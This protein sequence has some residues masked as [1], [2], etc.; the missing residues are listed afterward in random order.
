MAKSAI[1]ERSP[2]LVVS[3]TSITE[4][5]KELL[6]ISIHL[7]N[8]TQQLLSDRSTPALIDLDSANTFNHPENRPLAF[9][10]TAVLTYSIA[11][12]LVRNLDQPFRSSLNV[13]MP[14]G[15]DPNFEESVLGLRVAAFYRHFGPKH[16]FEEKL[17]S[18]RVTRA[19]NNVFVDSTIQAFDVTA[20]SG[21]VDE[22]GLR[23]SDDR[24]KFMGDLVSKR[25]TKYRSAVGFA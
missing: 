6:L 3:A 9:E 13:P 23:L 22:G 20:S 15:S 5:Q 8:T 7:L 14:D 12:S 11:K 18:I 19:V 1:G 24:L 21:L 16:D 17:F 25:L 10:I 2:D 4:T